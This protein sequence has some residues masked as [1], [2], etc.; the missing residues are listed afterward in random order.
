MN[1]TWQG[2]LIAIVSAIIGS[3]LTFGFQLF[4]DWKNS[5]RENKRV[6][7]QLKIDTY[8]KAIR[9]IGLCCT[10]YQ[11]KGQDDYKN[12]VDEAE[13]LYND[14]HPIFSIIASQDT[15]EEF[16]VLRNGAF[17]GEISHAEAYKK[18]IKILNFNISDEIK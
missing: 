7:Y 12:K 6:T 15:I 5:K 18:V 13:K 4:L 3:L 10:S 2:A 16:N 8:A 9:Y 14:F 17:D 11:H 1:E